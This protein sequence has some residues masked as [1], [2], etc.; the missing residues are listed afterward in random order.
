MFSWM[1]SNIQN[2]S[3]YEHEWGALKIAVQ[4][5]PI[6][7]PEVVL[8]CSNWCAIVSTKVD[9]RANAHPWLV[10]IVTSSSHQGGG[11]RLTLCED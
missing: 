2:Q 9:H 4:A 6:P 8:K 7:A 1:R 3:K 5:F 10:S 11:P